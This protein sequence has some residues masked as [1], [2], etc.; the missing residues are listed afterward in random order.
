MKLKLGPFRFPI[1]G[2][3]RGP[4]FSVPESR[5]PS[6]N[7]GFIIDASKMP[8]F[9]IYSRRKRRAA[10]TEPD[11]YQ[12]D[13]IPSALR[14]QVRRIFEKSLGR[15]YIP[16]AYDMSPP[17]N[18]NQ[19]WRDIRDTVA[20]EQGRLSLANEENPFRDCIAS[21][22]GEQ[23]VD[24][25]LDLVEYGILSA[26]I[27]IRGMPP[28]ARQNAGVEQDPDDAIKDLNFRFREA[29][30]GY[31]YESGRIMRVDSQYVHSE[32]VKPALQLLSDPRFK[33]AQDEFLAAH[34]HY[35]AGEF[36]DC[37]TDALNAFESTLK[38]ICE[39]RKWEYGKGAR[40][41]DLI[42]I[43]RN[44]GL[45]P[46]Y[47][48]NSFDQLVA[49]L[50]SGLPKVRNE[51]GGHGQGATR[52]ETPSYVAAYALHLAAAKIVL[53]VEAFRAGGK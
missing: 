6:T 46:E 39:A 7:K 29:A 10:Q 48:D 8:I 25:W 40:A 38:A 3:W 26:D 34:G 21:I 35:R 19:L 45:L 33:G 18:T 1:M 44:N 15:F 52:R 17:A 23:N 37:V 5:I 12:F 43:I 31:Q 22:H 4:A 50:Q 51:A 9:D 53:L 14:V 24:F 30:F 36:K 47:L 11:V 28:Y 2:H 42:K 32:V 41:S 27:V 49:T 20:Y 13:A 16:G